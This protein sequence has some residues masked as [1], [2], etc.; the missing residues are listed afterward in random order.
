MVIDA[1]PRLR[2]VVV[3]ELAAYEHLEVQL[4][5]GE[6]HPLHGGAVRLSYDG[7]TGE[8]VVV[9]EPATFSDAFGS[10][11]RVPV[12]L[13]DGAVALEVWLDRCSV[14]VFADDGRVVLTFLVFPQP[15]SAQPD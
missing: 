5:P 15:D 6:D 10:V 14:E 9:R 8:L 3:R 2:Q 13:V 7:T 1:G 11:S 12:P 4:R